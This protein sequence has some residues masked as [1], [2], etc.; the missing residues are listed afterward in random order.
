MSDSASYYFSVNK[1]ID[2]KW[3][4]YKKYKLRDALKYENWDIIILQQLSN[5]AGLYATYEPYLSSLLNKI[6]KDVSNKNVV[7]GWHMT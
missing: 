4:F 5:Q 2:N 7:F 1:G 6:N 3:K